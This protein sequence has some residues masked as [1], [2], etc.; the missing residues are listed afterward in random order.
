M[1]LFGNAKASGSVNFPGD[2]LL[3]MFALF[4]IAAV[5]VIVSVF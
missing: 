3:A 2:L 4:L 5:V 1:A